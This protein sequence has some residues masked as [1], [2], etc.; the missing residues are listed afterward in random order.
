MTNRESISE[1]AMEVVGLSAL[2]TAR[3]SA[4]VLAA[5]FLTV[6]GLSSSSAFAQSSDSAAGETKAAISDVIDEA[7]K[8]ETDKADEL[9]TNR[10]LRAQTGSLSKWSLST[11]FSYQGGTLDGPFKATRPNITGAAGT[12]AVSFLAGSLGVRYRISAVDSATLGIGLRMLTP[13]QSTTF[14]DARNNFDF[15]N[16][17]LSYTRLSRLGPIQSVSRVGTTVYTT[18]WDRNIG[19]VTTLGASQTL[20]AEIGQA[21]GLQ[22]GV[23]LAVD[24][25]F[26]DKRDEI[27]E[28]R[29]GVFD[30]AATQQ[31]DYGFGVYPFL[32]Y[33][34]NDR[35]NLRT[36][37]GV[38]VYEHARDEE[39]PF[40]FSRN[41]V[42]QSVG[43]GISVTRDV[44]LYPNL[45]FIPQDISWDRTNV[46]VTATVNL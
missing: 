26:H 12:E 6:S 17:G 5:T 28:V 27:V 33:V 22:A 46:G 21:T 19:R 20:L 29:R 38:W 10:M 39:N 44:F 23:L 1:A 24:A 16:P 43:L 11:S 14:E 36:I 13:F 2:S 42:Y 41:S 4:V 32:E 40:V 30:R 8:S 7:D 45:Q 35:F 18:A 25:S 3:M 37:S 31:S 15:T 34:I 9:I